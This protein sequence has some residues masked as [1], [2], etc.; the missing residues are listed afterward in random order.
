VRETPQFG[1]EGDGRVAEEMR[2]DGVKI[3]RKRLWEEGER[4]ECGK[5]RSRV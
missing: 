5:G 2:E 1:E 3:L 4:S